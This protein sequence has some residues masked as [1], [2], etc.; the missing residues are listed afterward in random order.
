VL[1]FII[2]HFF[3]LHKVFTFPLLWDGDVFYIDAVW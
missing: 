3:R 2:L 1:F